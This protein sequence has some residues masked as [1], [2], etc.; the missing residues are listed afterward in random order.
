MEVEFYQ[1]ETGKEVVAEFLESLPSKDVAKILRDIDLLAEHAP[2]LHEPY[3]KHI[4]GPIGELR[5]KFSS[6]IHRILYFVYKGN[7]LVLLHGF[8]QKTQNTP[9][10]EIELAKKRLNDYEKRQG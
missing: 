7:K 4:E 2:N 8:T 9:P 5:S 1:T 3:T 6:N 10:S